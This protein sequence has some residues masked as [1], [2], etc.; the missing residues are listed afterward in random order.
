MILR[1]YQEETI[2]K[3]RDGLRDGHRHQ[4]VVAPTG[5]GK[6]EMAMA[7]IMEA[8]KKQSRTAF[9][10]DRIALCD[11]TSARY[12]EN[13]IEHSV[14]QSGHW[15]FRPWERH[16][17][18]TIQTMTRRGMI[19]GLKLMI[20]DEAH[21]LYKG[22]VD[23]IKAHPDLIVVGLTATPF[24]KGLGAIYTNIVNVT[25]TNKLIEEQW[26]VPIKAYVAKAVD[27]TGA[28]IKF[29]GEWADKDIESRALK[30][31]GDVVSEWT[32][33]THQYFGGPAKTLVF[34][35]TVNHGEELCK[36][37]QQC[38]HNFQ[39]ISYKD[40]NDEKRRSLIEEFRKPDSDIV[41][42]VSCEALAKGF[43]CPDVLVGVSAKP[44]RKSLSGH[45]QQMG[46]VMRP[47]PGKEF[48]IWLDHAGNFL[49]FFDDTCEVFANGVPQ[50]DNGEM[51]GKV[52]KEPPKEKSPMVCGA[53]SFAMG[54]APTCPAC[55]WERPA[56]RSNILNIDGTMHEMDL[57]GSAR[58]VD[59]AFADKQSVWNQMRYIGLERKDGDD[60]AARQFALA[61]YRNLYGDWPKFIDQ[62]ADPMIPT[63]KVAN[64]V[65]SQLIAYFKRR[66]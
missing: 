64:K 6:T 22:T 27:M 32:A 13:R 41:G 44:Y 29:D 46:R 31:V 38:G 9:V 16:H 20:V 30:I 35:A 17:V 59:D 51:D 25:T 21:T 4:L 26:L 61:Q 36:Q 8:E 18:C 52:R 50:L 39:Q 66:A 63:R 3:L 12:A 42:L 60:V 55:G 14:M 62:N 47:S 11:Q 24:S 37:F 33:K 19:E 49:R 28:K 2:D 57:T 53:C 10:V 43:D 1:P 48:A 5:S 56:Q 34:S 15:R 54:A 65:K 58:N 45:I 7:L 40:G 23:Y